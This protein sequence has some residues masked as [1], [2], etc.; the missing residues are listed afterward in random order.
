L[1][2]IIKQIQAI[3][4][5]G[6]PIEYPKVLLAGDFFV[7]FGSYF[8]KELNQLY[9]QHKVIVKSTDFFEVLLYGLYFGAMV[10]G[11]Q[12]LKHKLMASKVSL[13]FMERIERSTR[14][15]FGKTGLIYSHPIDM[16]HIF[17]NA[18]TLINPMIFG[19]AIPAIGKG[20]ETIHANSF[21]SLI[22]IGPQF[23]LP[24]RISQAILKPV[25]L[26][27]RT[28]FLVYDAEVTGSSMS[29]NMRRLL[30]ANIQQIKRRK[31]ER[32]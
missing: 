1:K 21:D 27:N 13:R 14:R 31:E 30:L 15:L 10:S 17:D 2:K 6:N 5:K 25:Y 32:V 22:L 23:C 8:L 26:E 18:K 7:R 3:P 19:E 20:L 12:N 4:I 29:P 16:E 11:T 9:N 28:P 24:Y